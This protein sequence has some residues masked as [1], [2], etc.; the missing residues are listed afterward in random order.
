MTSSRIYSEK[1]YYVLM[2]KNRL[3]VNLV[4]VYMY[5]VLRMRV[6]MCR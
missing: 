2:F 6:Y 5:V 4:Y 1:P 3:V